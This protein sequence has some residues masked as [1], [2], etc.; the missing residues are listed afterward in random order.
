MIFSEKGAL[1]DERTVQAV[2]SRELR[3]QSDKPRALIIEARWAALILLGKKTAE[4]RSTDAT[5]MEGQLNFIDL[6]A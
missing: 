1:L 6:D 4:M 2:A 5:S 3:E